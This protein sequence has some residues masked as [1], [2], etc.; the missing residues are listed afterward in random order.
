MSVMETLEQPRSLAAYEKYLLLHKK[1][2]GPK[3]AEKL[4]LLYEDLVTC[5]DGEFQRMAGWAAAEAALVATDKSIAERL[6]MLDLADNS[7]HAAQLALRDHAE[8]RSTIPNRSSEMRVKTDRVFVPVLGSL[9]TQ[10]FNRQVRIRAFDELLALAVE[11]GVE[12]HDALRRGDKGTA[13]NHLGLAHEQNTYLGGNRLLSGR[14]VFIPSLARSGNGSTYARKTHD[15]QV[16]YLRRGKLRFVVPYEVKPSGSGKYDV[17]VVSAN[18]HLGASD[19]SS[20]FTLL[21]AFMREREGVSSPAED[22]LVTDATNN[23]IHLTQHYFRPDVLGAQ[24]L[25]QTCRPSY[26]PYHERVS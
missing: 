12:L 5:P 2:V 19:V 1:L 3:T 23:V 20:I 13:S 11:N 10:T 26:V 9:I 14:I 18:K 8:R 16:A 6:A 15:V 17:P 25:I 7:W 22:R 24:C 4:F 21:E